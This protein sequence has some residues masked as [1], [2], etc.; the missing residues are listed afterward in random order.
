MWSASIRPIRSGV[1]P[2]PNGT[3]ILTVFVGQSCA[4]TGARPSH[5]PSNAKAKLLFIEAVSSFSVSPADDPVITG[6]SISMQAQNYLMSP[7]S[8]GMTLP[9]PALPPDLP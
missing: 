7:L 8:R 9:D 1:E 2:G 4:A 5:R 3:T 6:D